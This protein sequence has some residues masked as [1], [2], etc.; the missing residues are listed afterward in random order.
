V[1]DAALLAELRDES[2]V[3][4]ALV[5]IYDWHAP[6]VRAHLCRV[7]LDADLAD[8]AVQ[9]AVI[10]LWQGRAALPER[11]SVRAW[12]AVIAGRRAVDAVRLGRWRQLPGGEPV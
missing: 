6:V 4:I 2:T 7:G 1:D 3:A 10:Q 5:A 12:L 9:E 8:D 11:L